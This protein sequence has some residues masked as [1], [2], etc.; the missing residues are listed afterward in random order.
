M[1]F[2]LLLL[3]FGTHKIHRHLVLLAQGSQLGVSKTLLR[4]WLSAPLLDDFSTK[5]GLPFLL[6]LDLFGS[7]V[8]N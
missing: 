2:L 8:P 5:F 3:G 4:L 1:V 7:M 6:T